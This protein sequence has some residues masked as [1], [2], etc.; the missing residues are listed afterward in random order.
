MTECMDDPD[1]EAPLA[2]L[3]GTL[4]DGTRVAVTVWWDGTGDI[5]FRPLNQTTFDPP[6]PLAKMDTS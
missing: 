5:A 3:G 2:V 6:I 1:R 4:P